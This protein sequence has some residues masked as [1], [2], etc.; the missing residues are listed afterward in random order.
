MSETSLPPD[1]NWRT[2]RN[3]NP[4]LSGFN[5]EQCIFHY[6]HHGIHEGR[7]YRP[8]IH[9][10]PAYDFSYD[11]YRQYLEVDMPKWCYEAVFNENPVYLTEIGGK[12]Y[13]VE[14]K[15]FSM[16]Y[17]LEVD[18]TKYPSCIDYVREHVIDIT[19]ERKCCPKCRWKLYDL[20]FTYDIASKTSTN[21]A[22]LSNVR[23][24]QLRSTHFE[25]VYMFNIGTCTME[26]IE[27]LLSRVRNVIRPNDLLLITTNRMV[28]TDVI[29]YLK[30]LK[31]DNLLWLE[32]PDP[33]FDVGQYFLSIC[34]MNSLGISYDYM[35]R[36][37]SKKIREWTDGLINPVISDRSRV[38]YV[39]SSMKQ[40]S[41]HYVG[42]P[43]YLRPLDYRCLRFIGKKFPGIYHHM[44]VRFVSGTIFFSSKEF[45]DKV[46]EVMS[47][48]AYYAFDTT[49]THNDNIY[50]LSF[51]HALERIFGVINYLY[52][53]KH[54]VVIISALLTDE[55]KY[56][57]VVEL[58][59]ESLKH[60]TDVVIILEPS[61]MFNSCLSELFT[62][63]NDVYFFTDAGGAGDEFGRWDRFF[64]DHYL[65]FTNYK[66]YIFATEDTTIDDTFPEFMNA[67]GTETLRVYGERTM[68]SIGCIRR[69]IEYIEEA[70]DADELWSNLSSY[71]QKLTSL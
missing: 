22:S 59:N 60:T 48:G 68:F 7:H 54:N 23:T 25:L 5:R 47:P 57:N 29:T 14:I 18:K 69:F 55:V 13:H 67:D 41:I 49:Y 42:A 28:P 39:I 51:S 15:F 1:F 16:F 26:L 4:D 45:N 3:L 33:G 56:R 6:L 53:S 70:T 62:D 27:Y 32:N 21:V 36:L 31:H 64:R 30:I 71:Y 9:S 8:P 24:G 10:G 58:V 66:K 61:G 20:N 52:F 35:F 46:I 50:E 65:E 63:R 2:Y 38:E 19:R 44:N 17:E 34:K 12:L 11:L 40:H 37:H 43:H